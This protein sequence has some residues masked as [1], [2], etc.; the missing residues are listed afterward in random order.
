M[1]CGVQ[2]LIKNN[3]DHMFSKWRPP[4]LKKKT[5]ADES[6]EAR[7]GDRAWRELKRRR[8]KRRKRR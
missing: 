1:N 7:P 2:F 8:W 4:V 5:F 6:G 3:I